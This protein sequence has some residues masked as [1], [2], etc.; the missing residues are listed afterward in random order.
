[1]LVIGF[2]VLLT[3]SPHGA[4][5]AVSLGCGSFGTAFLLAELEGG[6][7]FRPLWGRGPDAVAA[8]EE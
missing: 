1:M 8:A 6:R 5:H 3:G 4:V 7:P 2:A